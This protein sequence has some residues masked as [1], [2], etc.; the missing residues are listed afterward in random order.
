MGKITVYTDGST[1]G[2]GKED[3]ACGWACKLMWNGNVLVKSGS[4][5][6]RTNN[7]MEMRAVLEAMRS[8]TKKSIP[9]EVYSDSKY[10]VET[11]NGKYRMHKNQGLW[12]SLLIEKAKF[13]DIKF[14]WVK[15][16]DK[17][18][19][20]NEVDKIAAGESQKAAEKI[21][22]RGGDDHC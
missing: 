8:I 7:Q 1:I 21:Q 22:K 20:N 13:K 17:D 2:N 5:I 6:G 14:I 12:H 4:D 3:S 11:L 19:H 15:G 18:Q 9:V 10:V 16:H